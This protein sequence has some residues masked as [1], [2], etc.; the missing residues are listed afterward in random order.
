VFCIVCTVF[1]YCFICV[2]SYFFCLYQGKDYFHRVTTGSLVVVVV[3]VLV[4]L[5]VVVVVV[6]L[7][8]ILV[9]V[10]VVEGVV[11]GTVVVQ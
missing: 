1:L 7:P 9:V 11:M 6:V 10:V 2:Y 3:V 4:V 8:L 5:V